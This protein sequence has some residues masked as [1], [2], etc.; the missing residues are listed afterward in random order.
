MQVNPQTQVNMQAIIDALKDISGDS[1]ATGNVKDVQVATTADGL[2]ISFNAMVDGEL[3]PIVL[4]LTPE[5]DAPEGASDQFA[6]ET[7]ISKLD[8]LQ[9]DDMTQEEAANFMKEVIDKL[10]EKIQA[11]GGLTTTEIPSSKGSGGSATLFNLLEVLTLLV[12][13]GQEMKNAAKAVKAADNE[14][15]AQTYERAAD[16]T[17]AMAEAAKSQNSRNLA[18]SITMMV[19]S[20]AV[21]VGAACYGAAKAAMPA[22]KAAESQAKMANAVQNS[23]TNVENF[24]T[25]LTT[26]TGVSA[27]NAIGE[28][29]VGEIRSDF[30]QNAEINAA[31]AEVAAAKIAVNEA[32]TNV[33]NRQETVN[34]LETVIAANQELAQQ[35]PPGEARTALEN[36]IAERQTQLDTARTDLANAK[37][38]LDQ[39]NTRLDR[40]RS[41]FQDAVQN[42]MDK[43]ATSYT[44][45]KKAD[46]SAKLNE[47]QVANEFGMKMLKCDKIGGTNETIMTDVS[48]GKVV[49]QSDAS[50]RAAMRGESHWKLQA[51]VQI[52]QLGGQVSTTLSQ[53]WQSQVNYEAQGKQAD[54]QKSQAEGTR[55]QND[56]E[57]DKKLEDSADQVIQ[58]A[59]QTMLKA[60]DSE[61]QTTREIFS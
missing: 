4:A 2:T 13:V 11:N 20:A 6:I 41:G 22:T 35:M 52:G 23:N 61:H 10:V 32:S 54:A 8:E 43:Y 19:V 31:R 50:F 47:M 26:K 25:T 7:L 38:T 37:T 24:T 36:Q 56:Y 29:R 40:A 48:F 16:L 27:G 45:A 39:A 44:G 55:K 14:A 9:V 21:S 46:Q 17:M 60:F 42:V 51:A 5:L 28:Q 30:Q 59:N 33:A 53:H 12:Q 34:N 3:K 49:T 58:A 57:E 15:Q 1:L 18:I